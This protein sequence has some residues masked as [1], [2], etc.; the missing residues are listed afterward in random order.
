MVQAVKVNFTVKSFSGE[1]SI[2]V[3]PLDKDLD[4]LAG[5]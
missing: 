5:K 1:N 3:E 4:V 2:V